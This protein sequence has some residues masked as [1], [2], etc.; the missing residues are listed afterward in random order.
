[1]IH[2]QIG[3]EPLELFAHRTNKTDTPDRAPNY[4][5]FRDMKELRDSLLRDQKYIC[6]YCMRRISEDDMKIEHF[7]SQSTHPDLDLDYRNMLAVC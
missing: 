2:I 3:K 7:R 6:A 4:D 1:M 5:N